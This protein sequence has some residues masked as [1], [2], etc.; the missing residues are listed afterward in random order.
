M[1]ERSVIGLIL[2]HNVAAVEMLG[3]RMRNKYLYPEV[4]CG[5]YKNPKDQLS[6]TDVRTMVARVKGILRQVQ[7]IV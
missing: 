2:N 1:D 4:V 6:M 5:T 3:A 7:R